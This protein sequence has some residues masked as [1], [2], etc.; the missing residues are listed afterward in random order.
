MSADAFPVRLLMT[1][2]DAENRRTVYLNNIPEKYYCPNCTV[3]I[4]SESLLMSWLLYGWCTMGA[5][6]CHSVVLL[7]IVRFEQISPAHCSTFDRHYA[8]ARMRIVLT[9]C[10]LSCHKKVK[11]RT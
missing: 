8:E 4:I 1:Q 10:V 3:Y 9:H 7:V 2:N 11:G 6:A 5:Y